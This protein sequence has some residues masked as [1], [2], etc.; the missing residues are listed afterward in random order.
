MLDYCLAQGDSSLIVPQKAKRPRALPPGLAV[1]V[2]RYPNLRSGTGITP[3][4]VSRPLFPRIVAN[5]KPKGKRRPALARPGAHRAQLE[6]A[7]RHRPHYGRIISAGQR[8]SIPFLSSFHVSPITGAIGK[9]LGR[10]TAVSGS[11]LTA[12]ATRAVP[13][14]RT[15]GLT[16][17]SD[18]RSA[19]AETGLRPGA[20]GSALRGSGSTLRSCL[21]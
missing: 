5:P 6:H 15:A 16:C 4:A 12:G 18:L 1:P 3:V 7:S 2:K 13:G 11:A 17:F 19:L 9:P 21:R 14:R 8:G 20:A 10:K